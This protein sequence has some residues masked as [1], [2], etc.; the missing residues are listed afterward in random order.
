MVRFFFK[1]IRALFQGDRCGL[2]GVETE[3]TVYY[4]RA[5]YPTVERREAA[6][7]NMTKKIDEPVGAVAA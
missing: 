7:K 3:K 2:E 1:S 4:L 5:M 6:Q